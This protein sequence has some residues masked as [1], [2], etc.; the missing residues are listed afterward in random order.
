MKNSGKEISFENF[1]KLEITAKSGKVMCDNA[2]LKAG[3][4]SVYAEKVKEG[5][6]R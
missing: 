5:N 2:E 3:N 6:V 1:Q 4:K